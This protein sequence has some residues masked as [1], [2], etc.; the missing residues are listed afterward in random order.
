MGFPQEENISIFLIRISHINVLKDTTIIVDNGKS[1]LISTKLIPTFCGQQGKFGR[2]IGTF[3][4][5]MLEMTSFKI[6][7][8]NFDSD[9]Y[10]NVLEA[11]EKF[12]QNETV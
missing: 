12:L 1:L 7:T 6:F 10:K 11:R 4:N 8:T 2:F 5:G 9:L 3:R